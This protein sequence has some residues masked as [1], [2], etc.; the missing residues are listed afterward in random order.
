MAE[1]HYLNLA[2]YA[3]GPTDYYFLCPVLQRLCENICTR[4][5]SGPVEVSEVLPL[6]DP[7]EHK[8]SPREQRILEAAKAANGSW[9]VLFI[10]TDG[11]GNKKAARD[12]L[13]RPSIE[14][15]SRELHTLGCAVAVIPVRET[16]SWALADGDAIRA[17]FGTRKTN[18]ELGIPVAARQIEGVADPKLTLESAFHATQPPQSR[19]KQGVSP[20][21]NAI[22][23]QISIDQLRQIQAF[24]E[25]EQELRAA[26]RTL[27]ILR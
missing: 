13:V 23:E 5:A 21:L 9:R 4:E 1:M 18:I 27:N 8:N 14:L 7:E 19:K 2:L 3:E 17:A 15:I 25:L 20:Y 11:G 6:D 24:C 16:E 10:H 26:L 22:G 12:N